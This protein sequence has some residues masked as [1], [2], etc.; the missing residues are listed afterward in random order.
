[1]GYPAEIKKIKGFDGNPENDESVFNIERGNYLY[2]IP[3]TPPVLSGATQNDIDAIL[4]TF[5]FID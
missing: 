3:K 4:S 2:I 5:K 1:L